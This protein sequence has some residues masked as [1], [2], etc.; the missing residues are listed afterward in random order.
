MLVGEL[1]FIFDNETIILREGGSKT[2]PPNVWQE[3]KS[4]YGGKTLTIFKNSEFDIFLAPTATLLCIY[5]STTPLHLMT[6][7]LQHYLLVASLIQLTF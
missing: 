1:E 6:Q 2:S 5:L 3:A 7:A 4:V